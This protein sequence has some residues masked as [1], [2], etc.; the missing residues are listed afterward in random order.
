MLRSLLIRRARTSNNERGSLMDGFETITNNALINSFIFPPSWCNDQTI[1]FPERLVV[2][3]N[4][5]RILIPRYL[6]LWVTSYLTWKCR[7]HVVWC[8]DFWWTGSKY[9]T[10]Y[11]NDKI[12]FGI[13]TYSVYLSSYSWRWALVQNI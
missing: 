10:N 6:R 4:L 7:V 9:K 3:R 11:K 8:A 2:V 5:S 12:I 1:S 13:V